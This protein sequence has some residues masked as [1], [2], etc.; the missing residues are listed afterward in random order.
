MLPL[1]DQENYYTGRVFGE[2]LSD[3]KLH[4]ED[5][6]ITGIIHTPDETYH[7]EVN[8]SKHLCESTK[9]ENCVATEEARITTGLRGLIG[10]NCQTLLRSELLRKCFSILLEVRM[11]GD[12]L[13]QLSIAGRWCRSKHP[14]LRIGMMVGW[15]HPG[16]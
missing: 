2:K 1:L 6:V 10:T 3:V 16:S 14:Q 12:G 5:G 4:M 7:I 9:G 11:A 15:S 13:V 8:K